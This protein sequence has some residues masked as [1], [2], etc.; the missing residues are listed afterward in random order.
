MYTKGFPFSY[1]RYFRIISCGIDI[2]LINIHCTEAKVNVKSATRLSLNSF[3]IT[4]Q[5]ALAFHQRISVLCTYLNS[6]PSK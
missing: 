2:L 1:F 3:A 6:K 4:L 5:A